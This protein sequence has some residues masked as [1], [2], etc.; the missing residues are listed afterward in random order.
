MTFDIEGLL[1]KYPN[2]NKGLL[3]KAIPPW[4]IS[5]EEAVKLYVE[6]VK[7]IDLEDPDTDEAIERVKE[8][9]KFIFNFCKEKELTFDDYL[10]Y[11]EKVQP[12]WVQHLKSHEINFYLLHSLQLSKP[13]LDFE[14]LEFTISDFGI[15]YAKTK[16]KFYHSK[17]MKSFSKKANEKLNTILLARNN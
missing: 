14:L 1:L 6:Y 16:Q 2:I 11:C 7:E 8:G 17:R 12:S 4:D 3:E 13:V 5:E 9:F 15:K 10:L